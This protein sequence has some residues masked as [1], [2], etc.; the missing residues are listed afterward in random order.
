MK[1]LSLL[2]ALAMVMLSCFAANVLAA[3]TLAEIQKRG[4]L[5]VGME[6]GYMPF[7]LDFWHPDDIDLCPLIDMHR[8]PAHSSERIRD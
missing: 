1:K 6:P 2:V 5:R 8:D 4:S 7:D 3:D